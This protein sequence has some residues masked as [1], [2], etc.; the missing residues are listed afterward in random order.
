MTRR[1]IAIMPHTW[2]EGTTIAAAKRRAR[3]HRPISMEVQVYE[4]GPTAQVDDQGNISYDTADMA[5][6]LVE[7][8]DA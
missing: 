5:P 2:G 4:V 3:T 7:R 1:Y 6:K 8:A